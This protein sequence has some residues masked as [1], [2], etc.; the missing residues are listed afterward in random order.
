MPD[1]ISRPAVTVERGGIVPDALA[2]ELY[3]KMLAVYYIE[4]RMKIFVKQGK[5]SFHASTRGHEKLQIGMALLLDRKS[6]V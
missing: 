2:V 1:P 5:C 6:V 3:R 4:E